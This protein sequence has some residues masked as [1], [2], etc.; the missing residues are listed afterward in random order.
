MI[1]TI[2]GRDAGAG[3]AVADLAGAFVSVPRCAEAV[4]AETPS[5]I[6]MDMNLKSGLSL[7]SSTIPV[8]RAWASG[9]W[10]TARRSRDRIRPRC[11]NQGPDRLLPFAS[12]RVHRGVVSVSRHALD[13]W[14]GYAVRA[15]RCRSRRVLPRALV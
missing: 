4:M 6:K 8:W 12:A 7:L 1:K 9:D 5:A 14:P 2:L 13:Q 3:L 11:A 10:A 15:G